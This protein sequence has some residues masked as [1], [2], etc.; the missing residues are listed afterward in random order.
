MKTTHYVITTRIE[1][2]EIS[3]GVPVRPPYDKPEPGTRHVGEVINL[4][5]KDAQLD[6]LLVRAKAHLDLVTDD[7]NIPADRLGNLRG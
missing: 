6:V 5:L 4:T 7:P 1:R 2:V 3:D